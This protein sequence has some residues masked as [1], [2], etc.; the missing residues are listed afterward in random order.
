VTGQVKSNAAIGAISGL[1]KQLGDFTV[2]WKPVHDSEMAAGESFPDGWV[3]VAASPEN[4]LVAGTTHLPAWPRKANRTQM[5]E[6]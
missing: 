6:R 1:S 3:G 5:H 4:A 2:K